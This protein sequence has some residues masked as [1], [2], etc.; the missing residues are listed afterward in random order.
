MIASLLW[1]VCR[2]VRAER[3]DRRVR[4]ELSLPDEYE[5]NYAVGPP[6]GEGDVWPG[7]GAPGKRYAL[8]TH[9]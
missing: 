3:A 9:D 8:V 1:C 6:A 5:L 7:S 2:R 4:A